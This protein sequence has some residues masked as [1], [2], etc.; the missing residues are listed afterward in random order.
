MTGP[1]SEQQIDQFHEQGFL[2]CEQFFPPEVHE[3]LTSW[4]H[5]V[6]DW[7]DGN[8][9]VHH[10]EQ[11]ET[12][13]V[14]ARTERFMANHDGLKGL[15]SAG[16]L[17]GALSQLFAEPACVFKEKINYKH[18]GGAGFHPH[19][20]AAAYK[21]FGSLHITCLVAIDENTEE[22]GCLWFAPGQHREPVPENDAGCIDDELASGWEWVSAPLAPGGALFFSSLIPH[23]SYTN[24][25]NNS[26]R[27]LY[28]TYGKVSEGNLRDEYYQDRSRVMAENGR[29]RI[30]T[31]GHFQGKVIHE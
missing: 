30:S 13:S 8:R 25:T 29:P 31:I 6:S 22:N 15:L 21:R 3:Q 5:E 2:R 27:S 19:Q 20:D 26:R 18:P 9:C 10:H 28:V 1:L 12:G 17:V 14:L 4:V 11:T 23:R 7:T 24:N 16:Q